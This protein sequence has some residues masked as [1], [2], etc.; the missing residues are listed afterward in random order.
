MKITEWVMSIYEIPQR[1]HQKKKHKVDG[2]HRSEITY[3][4]KTK[5]GLGIVGRLRRKK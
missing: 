4:H 1:V 3:P 5:N 2:H